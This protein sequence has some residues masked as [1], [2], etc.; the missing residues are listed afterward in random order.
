MEAVEDGETGAG[1]E[2]SQMTEI[3]GNDAEGAG[4]DDG[5]ARRERQKRTRARGASNARGDRGFEKRA[6]E[7]RKRF[8]KASRV[9][10]ICQ[11]EDEKKNTTAK[12]GKERAAARGMAKSVAQRGSGR[13]GSFG[14]QRSEDR[15]L[16]WKEGGKTDV[17]S[18][19]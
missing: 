14:E 15:C 6:A 10:K 5:N 13:K 18:A 8:K 3:G 4:R 19:G 7:K 9:R 16:A 2:E 12:T 11:R 17:R 1:L